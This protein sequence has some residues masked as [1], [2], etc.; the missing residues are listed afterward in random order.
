MPRESNKSSYRNKKKSNRVSK[1]VNLPI[2][3]NSYRKIID[4][5]ASD[6]LFAIYR[7]IKKCKTATDAFKAKALREGKTESI[8]SAEACQYFGSIVL[9]TKDLVNVDILPIIDQHIRIRHNSINHWRKVKHF[10]NKRIINEHIAKIYSILHT[11]PLNMDISHHEARCKL[12]ALYAARFP[13]PQLEKNQDIINKNTSIINLVRE[14][15]ESNR[16]GIIWDQIPLQVDDSELNDKIAAF[17]SYIF[18]SKDEKKEREIEGKFLDYIRSKNEMKMK[19]FDGN[20]MK[21][22]IK[23]DDI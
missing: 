8:A 23:W 14:W 6:K 20:T 4:D 11:T 7:H 17:Y 16:H 9:T 10:R 12:F 5:E 19:H 2:R 18:H 22:S 3:I 1:R 13:F 21:C 15:A